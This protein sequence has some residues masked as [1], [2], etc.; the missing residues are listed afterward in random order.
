MNEFLG[1][2]LQPERAA[3]LALDEGLLPAVPWEAGEAAEGPLERALAET[4]ASRML[5]LPEADESR[6]RRDAD[7]DEAL[8]AALA[9]FD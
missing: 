4:A 6:A 8:R 3:A 5:V 2:L 7:F 9:L 1:W